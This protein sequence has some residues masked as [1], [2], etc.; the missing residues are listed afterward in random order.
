VRQVVAE[1]PQRQRDV[2]RLRYGLV[3]DGEPVS[4]SETARQ[5]RLR[6]ADVRAI[7]QSALADLA[8][9]REIAAAA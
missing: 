6:P 9:R 7:E 3:G 1:L 4:A 2:I 5:L 8:L